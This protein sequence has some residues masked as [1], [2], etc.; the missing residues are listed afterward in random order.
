MNTVS[1]VYNATHRHCRDIKL[2]NL[3]TDD[4]TV[5]LRNREH[6]FEHICHGESGRVYVREWDQVLEIDC[7]RLTFTGPIK[8]L[9]TGIT[10]CYGMC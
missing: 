9:H 8:S 10:M 5:A 4:V 1:N 7:S 3:Q 2:L 6:M